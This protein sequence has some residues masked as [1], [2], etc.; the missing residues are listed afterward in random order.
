MKKSSSLM[1]MHGHE[2]FLS[3]IGR[4]MFRSSEFL[5]DI[6]KYR[7]LGLESFLLR[8]ESLKLECEEM[9][10]HAK[11]I[12]LNELNNIMGLIQ[13]GWGSSFLSQ[14]DGEAYRHLVYGVA[15]LFEQYV[16]PLRPNTDFRVLLMVG[17]LD[18]FGFCDLEPEMVATLLELHRACSQG[19]S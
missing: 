1:T 12:S 9:M 6:Q 16:A 13:D 14:K 18:R 4:T 3:M 8:T 17:M 2:A 11:S 7:V 10:R 15:G 5:R 19:V